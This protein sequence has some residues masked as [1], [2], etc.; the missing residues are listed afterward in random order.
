VGGCFGYQTGNFSSTGTLQLWDVTKEIQRV[1]TEQQTHR[2]GAGVKTSCP[3]QFLHKDGGRDDNFCAE[4][5]NSQNR[6]LT[7]EFLVTCFQLAR[8]P[9]A[10]TLQLSQSKVRSNPRVQLSSKGVCSDPTEEA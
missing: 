9:L 7:G 2:H 4:T 6:W 5:K 3:T 10:V 1:P 8:Y